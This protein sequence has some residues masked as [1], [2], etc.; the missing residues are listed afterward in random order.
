M[1]DKPSTWPQVSLAPELGCSAVCRSTFNPVTTHGQTP[2]AGGNLSTAL[3]SA[4]S[5]NPQEL[6]W[7]HVFLPQKLVGGQRLG[8]YSSQGKAWIWLQEVFGV[9]KEGVSGSLGPERAHLGLSS[10]GCGWWGWAKK[11]ELNNTALYQPDWDL[12]SSLYFHGL[13]KQKHFLKDKA[14][15]DNINYRYSSLDLCSPFPA[16]WGDSWDLGIYTWHHHD[17]LD[18][19]RRTVR[20]WMLTFSTSHDSSSK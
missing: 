9:E 17:T 1:N 6:S 4:K 15:Y 11:M 13:L 19:I 2:T 12:F 14:T 7:N 20:G 8:A 3:G 18:K 5:N 16:V 10:L